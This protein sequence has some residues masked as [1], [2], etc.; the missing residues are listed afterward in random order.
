M[1]HALFI[2]NAYEGIPMKITTTLAICFITLLASGCI[3]SSVKG[4]TDPDYVGYKPK[5]ILVLMPEGFSKAFKSQI[6]IF[7]TTEAVTKNDLFLPTR[8]YTDKKLLDIINENNIDATLSISVESD[9]SSTSVSSYQTYTNA[10][11]QNIGNTTTATGTTTTVPVTTSQRKS[12][13][14]IKLNSLAAI[15]NSE[16]QTVWIGSVNTSAKGDIYTDS[17]STMNSMAKETVQELIRAGHL[18]R[19]I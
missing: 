4:F 11:A 1:C 8:T 10:T 16:T 15:N 7:T 14:K 12:S 18:D 5:K 3:S 19:K 13:A 6:E 9:N 2:K 17:A